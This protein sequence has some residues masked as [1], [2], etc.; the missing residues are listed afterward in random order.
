MPGNEPLCSREVYFKSEGIL[1]G[2][3]LYLLPLHLALSRAPL[4]RS[5][6]FFGVA[7]P[8]CQALTFRVNPLDAD[9][10]ASSPGPLLPYT[11]PGDRHRPR[12]SDGFSICTPGTPSSS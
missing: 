2:T 9:R 12:T 1:Y 5:P 4:K 8:G 3:S 11:W 6:R 10:F 7:C